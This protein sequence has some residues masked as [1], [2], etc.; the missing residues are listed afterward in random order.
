M[1]AVISRF[2]P[3][4]ALVF[5]LLAMQGAWAVVSDELIETGAT[6]QEESRLTGSPEAS[7]GQSSGAALTAETV[8]GLS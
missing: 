1:R 5:A 8:H 3:C 6:Q 4:S 7:E 2:L